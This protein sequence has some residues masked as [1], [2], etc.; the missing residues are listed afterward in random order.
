[1]LAATTGQVPIVRRLVAASA[2]L[3]DQNRHGDTALILAS[4]SGHSEAVKVLVDAGASK[5]IRNR[6]GVAAADA[7]RMRGFDG[8]ASLLERG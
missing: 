8:I 1:M 3:N 7:A 2:N 6:E 5:A 4:R